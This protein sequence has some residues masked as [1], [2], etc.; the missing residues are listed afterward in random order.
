LT[1]PAATRRG[2]H[3]SARLGGSFELLFDAAIVGHKEIALARVHPEAKM[4]P[5]GRGGKKLVYVKKNGVDFVGI[6]FGR[7]VAIELKRLPN[8]A[9]LRTSKD[10]STEAEARFLLEFTRAGGQGAF[11]VYDPER[12]RIYLVQGA[13]QMEALVRGELVPLRDRN[14]HVDP[15]VVWSDVSGAPGATVLAVRHLVRRLSEYGALVIR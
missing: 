3:S 6:A 14:G 12:E 15:G 5:D 4:I 7:A 9:S 1:S 11:L 2:A 8:A 10:D 13:G